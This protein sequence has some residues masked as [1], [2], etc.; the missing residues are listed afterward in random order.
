MTF[1]KKKKKKGYGSALGADSDSSSSVNDPSG[2]INPDLL[3]EQRNMTSPLRPLNEKSSSP[4][5]K[6]KLDLEEEK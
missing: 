5:S 6:I 4:L 1:K 2:E 3:K